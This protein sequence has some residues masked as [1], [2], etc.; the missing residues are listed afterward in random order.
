MVH[1]VWAIVMAL[2]L[3]WLGALTFAIGGASSHLLLV[4]ALVLLVAQLQTAYREA[5]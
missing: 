5:L 4:A 1:V 2:I 3:L